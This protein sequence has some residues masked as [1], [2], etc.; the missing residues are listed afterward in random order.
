MNSEHT[1]QYPEVSGEESGLVP[2][3]GHKGEWPKKIRTL[4]ANDLD[5]LTIDSDGRFYWDGHLV[6]YHPPQLAP[7]AGA[8]DADDQSALELLDRAAL[9]LTADAHPAPPVHAPAPVAPPVMP[10]AVDL[11]VAAGQTAPVVA[12]PVSVQTVAPAVEL[13]PASHPTLIA[14]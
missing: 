2:P 13:Q 5:R 6:N 12:P 14:P 10:R 8:V 3:Q 11:D 9:E 4:S 7:T 1:D